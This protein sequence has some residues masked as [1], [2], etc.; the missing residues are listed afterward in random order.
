MLDSLSIGTSIELG[1]LTLMVLLLGFGGRRIP[2]WVNL[3]LD[4]FASP[5]V[6]EFYQK[7]VE[8]HQ[9]LGWI[10]AILGLVELLALLI[11][12]KREQAFVEVPVSLGLTITASWFVS[13]LFKQFFEFYILEAVIKSGR[14]SNSEFL[15]LMQLLVN[16][17]I[18]I[19]AIVLFAQTHRINIVGLIAS[20]G[21]GG[22]SVA[23]AAQKTLE[24]LLGGIVLY[25]DRPFVVD[26]YIGLPDGVFGRVE[27]IGLRSTKIRTSG[28]GTLVI[29]PN[30]SLTQLTIENYTGGKKVMALVY[31]NF[32][33][34]IAIADRALVQKIIIDST[35]DIFGIDTQN[36][37]VTFKD[38][39]DALGQAR[40]QAQVT[41]F[42]L[43]SEEV[44]MTL[45]RQLLDIA[46]QTITEKLKTY[47]IT[48][49][50]EEPT[51]YVDAPITI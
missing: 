2:A 40:S 17:G 33:Q 50:I 8:P 6:K 30:S 42:I 12:E 20:L 1:L 15:I 51:I 18:V 46:N 26:D 39:T 13:R 38:F 35:D 28:K 4:R 11:P 47:G 25:L 36:T 10:V 9:E 34:V 44:S 49:D 29:V 41:F 14:K 3:L 48:F 24:Q 5:G 43:G 16:I 22:L 31:L 21:I 7:V 27:S 32:Y 23:F 19:I 37:I 45:R